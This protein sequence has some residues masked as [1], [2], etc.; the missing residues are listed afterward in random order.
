[1]RELPKPN[2]ISID[3]RPYSFEVLTFRLVCNIYFP[4]NKTLRKSNIEF[5]GGKEL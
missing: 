1:M 5:F 4:Q 3:F 2:S